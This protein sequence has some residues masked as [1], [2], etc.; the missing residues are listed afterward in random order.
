M[1][2][3]KHGTPY[4]QLSTTLFR[5]LSPSARHALA[6]LRAELPTQRHPELPAGK[7]PDEDA[8]SPPQEPRGRTAVP[9]MPEIAPEEATAVL[10]AAG[11]GGARQTPEEILRE[12]RR[13]T[14]GRFA[15]VVHTA[16]G[17]FEG[18]VFACGRARAAEAKVI[19]AGNPREHA[20]LNRIIRVDVLDV[21][22]HRARAELVSLLGR[23]GTLVRIV[24]YREPVEGLI[25]GVQPSRFVVRQRDGRSIARAI[26]EV[27]R[28]EV[29]G[30][31]LGSSSR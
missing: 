29:L 25:V 8:P 28:V 9:Q 6:E 12:V 17:S 10:K 27:V 4:A 22:A 2:S 3:T 20:P 23:G 16:S 18:M 31:W 1:A 11:T 14:V 21:R 24:T 30:Q 19:L 7:A 26:G 15:V 13:A 5:G